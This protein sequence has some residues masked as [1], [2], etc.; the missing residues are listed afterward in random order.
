VVGKKEERLLFKGAPSELF[1]RIQ[2]A[3]LD[4]YLV[5]L[6][7][8]ARGNKKIEEAVE[9]CG[10]PQRKVTDHLGIHFS[11]IIRIRELWGNSGDVDSYRALLIF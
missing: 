6:R 7:V 8:T 3:F 11:S 2:L 10:Y 9:R 4:F 1:V 5:Y